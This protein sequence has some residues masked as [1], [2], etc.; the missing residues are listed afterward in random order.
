MPRG[1]CLHVS[2]CTTCV[3][4]GCVKSVEV[5]VYIT[6]EERTVGQAD[7]LSSLGGA[8][9]YTAQKTGLA[10]LCI[11]ELCSYKASAE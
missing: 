1:T 8:K 2:S 11:N 9:T 4:P 7:Y 3:Y 6:G 5:Y 10:N